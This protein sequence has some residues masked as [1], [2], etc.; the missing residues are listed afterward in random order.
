MAIVFPQ[1]GVVKNGR[2]IPKNGDAF[3][4][5]FARLEGKMCDV[6]VRD[7]ETSR[8]NKQLRYLFGVVYPIIMEETGYTSKEQHAVCCAE[9]LPPI[10]KKGKEYAQSTTGMSTKEMEQYLELLRSWGAVF[11]KVSIPLPN[12]AEDGR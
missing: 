2:F 10:I 11:L 8:S 1:A 5:Q 6:I 12:E 7:V 9:L 4:L 3:K